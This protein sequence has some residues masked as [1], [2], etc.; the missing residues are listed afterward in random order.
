MSTIEP[1]WLTD[2][3][4]AGGATDRTVASVETTPL[5]VSSAAGELARLSV[6]YDSSNAGPATIIAKAPGAG[7]VQRMMDAAMGLFSREHFVYAEVADALPVQLPHCYYA[8]DHDKEEPMLLEDLRHLRMGDQVA[9][10]DRRDAERLVDLLADMHSD[11]WESDP[12]GG[13]AS[14][15]VSWCDPVLSAMVTQLVTSGVATLRERYA[16]RVPSAVLGAIE[17]AAPDWAGVL[18]RCAEGPQTFV[19]NDFRLDNIFFQTDG[20]PVVIDWQ[21][22]GRCRGTQDL[23]YLLSGSMA[24]DELR[25]CWEDLVQRYHERLVDAGVSGYDLDECRYHYRQSLLYTVAPG[26]AMLGQMQLQGGDTRGLADT[27]VLR[28]LTHA[29]ELDAFATL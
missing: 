27:L 3:L 22:A 29:G 11:F 17:D 15:L 4:H 1:K 24:T 2:V 6:T 12:P 10:L 28:T 16:D 14:R 5:E 8:G 26:I 9:G 13:D 20:V 7:E 23:A 21:L 19:H 25:D 18:Q